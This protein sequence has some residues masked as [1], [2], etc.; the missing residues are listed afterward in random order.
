MFKKI[1]FNL[2]FIYQAVIPHPISGQKSHFPLI[3]FWHLQKS[4]LL[5]S[6]ADLVK[7]SM[8]AQCECRAFCRKGKNWTVTQLPLFAEEC[9]SVCVSSCVC[10]NLSPIPKTCGCAAAV[11][12]DR[13]Y[14]RRAHQITTS[15]PDIQKTKARSGTAHTLTGPYIVPL[16]LK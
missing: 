14:T 1:T 3:P 2:T 16:Q 7:L 4:P 10:I 11:I 13:Q 8:M 5:F 15:W 9:F 6:L 12:N